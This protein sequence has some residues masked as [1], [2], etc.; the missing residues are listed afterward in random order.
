MRKLF[1][2]FVLLSMVS[3]P[4]FAGLRDGANATANHAGSASGAG[5]AGRAGSIGGAGSTAGAGS[6]GSVA[7]AGSAVGGQ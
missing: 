2:A 4:A 1:I 6:A 7:S 3:T 5:A